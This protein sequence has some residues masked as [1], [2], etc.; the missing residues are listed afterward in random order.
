[1]EPNTGMKIWETNLQ[2]LKSRN[3]AGDLIPVLPAAPLKW[4]RVTLVPGL[5]PTLQVP[6]EKGRPVTLHSPR[7]AW[8]EA[9]VL[10][11]RAP[12]APSRPLLALG[13]G[14][15]YHLLR[16]LPRLDP[17]QPLVI[18]EQEPEIFW[19]A[20][21]TLDLTPLLSRPHTTLVVHPAALEV[22]SH[23]QDCL[24]LGN[25]GGSPVLWGHPASLRAANAFYQEVISAFQGP[26]VAPSRSYG[27]KKEKLRVLVVNTDYFLIPEVSRALGRLGHEVQVILFD[28]RRDNGEEVLQKILQ[29]VADFAPDLVFTVNHL[30]FDREGLLMEALNRLR[31]P[32]VSWYVDS[33]AIILNLYAGPKSDLSYI[34][35]W[36]PTYVPEVKA[37]G[38]TQVYPLPLATDPETF[39]PQPAA[40]RDR[41]RARVAFVG[42]SMT[43]PLAKKL[44]RLPASP[45]VP[46]L[47]QQL[48]DA[49]QARPYRRL[50]LLLAEL[51]LE[52][53][54]LIRQLQG[55]ELTDLEA[56]VIWAATRDY[57][58][59][60]VRQLAC[61]QPT[62]YGDDGW[63]KLLGPSFRLGPIVNYYDDLPAIYGA[64]AI[65]FNATSMQMKAAVN[66]RVFDVPAAGGF[67]ITDFKEQLAEVLEPGK[68]SVCYH[69]PEEIPD[70]VRFYLEHPE[71]RRQI[72]QR[73]QARVLREHTYRHRLQEM[74]AVLRRTM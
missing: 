19:A 64:T 62:I 3:L 10:A 51:G 70:L 48:L 4:Q 63:Q 69:H 6:G 50:G 68:E 34:F 41:W 13:L 33:P 71:A 15:G 16:L 35:V 60:C 59:S 26:R 24:H 29:R 65:N 20:L 27:L 74:L 1:M 55:I 47:F 58:L 57:R 22:I 17:E 40:A 46:V 2:A 52:N 38:F 45:E 67:L 25:G 56:G 11:A 73:G 12:L 53:H 66:Q 30:G 39:Y 18:V 14:L 43:Q 23:L 36:D 42:N 7:E 32:S 5:H 31:L 8:K 54:P 44:G 9:E 49:Y 61:F 72:A 37:L 21:Q 28:K